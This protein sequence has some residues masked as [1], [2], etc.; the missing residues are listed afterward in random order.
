[1][2]Q[3]LEA[4]VGAAALDERPVRD[5]WPQT[6]MEQRAGK[7]APR[8]LVARPS[9]REQVASILRWATASGVVVTP[10][11][12]GSGVCGAVAP[13]AGELVLDMG[14]FDRILEVDETNL[15]CRCESGVNGMALEQHLNQ[16][17]LT[18]GHF[19]SSL[20]GTTVG[21]L[22]ATRS[23]GQESSRYGSIE[24]MVI[25]LAVVMPDGTFAGPRPG[26][27]SSLGPALHELYLGSEGALGVIIGA[28]LKV[29]RLPEFVVGRG[30]AFADLTSALEAMRAI[31]QAGIRPLLM[32]LYD[33][34]DAAFNG[35]D[36]PLGACVL[37]VATAGLQA[38]AKAEADAV[39]R[40]VGSADDLGEEPWNRWLRHRFDLSAERLKSLLEPPGAYLDVIELAAPWTVLP[41][42]HTRVKAA[43]GVGGIALCHFSHAYEQG[44]CAYFSFAGARDTEDEARSAY[45]R[46]W[47]G[48]MSSALEL[49]ATISHHHGAGQARARWIAD[50]MG[51]WM[52]L[53]RSV[54]VAVDPAGVMNPRAL[55]GAR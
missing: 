23:S 21:G 37:V 19:P 52:R 10:L 4:I 1:M 12:G 18:L 31:M 42:L 48:A 2:R 44:C 14:G 55:G 5:L 26:P 28:V 51:G 47:E 27:R 41:Q 15:I 3:E 49:G 30:F 25:S 22:C 39:T 20:A 9:G 45:S 53:W 35:Y 33:P 46:A 36:L 16:R 32:R 6:I 13:E 24:D 54:K 34:E 11:G 50:E 43:I 40:F 7:A 8:V 29:H 17:G 38:V